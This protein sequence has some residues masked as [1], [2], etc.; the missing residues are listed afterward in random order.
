MISTLYGSF[1]AATGIFQGLILG[2]LKPAPV[3]NFVLTL[4][5]DSVVHAKEQTHPRLPF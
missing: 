2:F 5:A 4:P 3:S 1:G